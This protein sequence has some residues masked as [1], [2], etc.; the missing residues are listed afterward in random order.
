MLA[1]L[2]A[3]HP[4]PLPP[5]RIIHGDEGDGSESHWLSDGPIG[6]SLWR[7]L[8]ATRAATGLAPVLAAPLDDD[9]R[10]PFRPWGSGECFPDDTSSPAAHDPAATLARWWERRGDGRAWPGTAAG[11]SFAVEAADRSEDELAEELLAVRQPLRLV[12]ARGRSA[13]EALASAGWSGPANYG[14]DFAPYTA[15]LADWERRYGARVVAAGFAELW[16]SLAVPPADPVR[17]AGEHL[18]FCPDH[19][20]QG[21]GL[22]ASTRWHFWWD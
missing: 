19:T 16:V 7:D 14:A 10:E 2:L 18:A 22:A 1:D 5:G 21:P 17:V 15:I 9:P 12:L 4:V 6:I 20:V 11:E 8:V 13:A 3:A